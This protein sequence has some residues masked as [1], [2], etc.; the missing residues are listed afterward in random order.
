MSDT[1]FEQGCPSF[2]RMYFCA[3]RPQC[4]Y[5]LCVALLMARVVRW[6][7]DFWKMIAPQR[8]KVDSFTSRLCCRHDLPTQVLWSHSNG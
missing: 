1:A 5:M 4:G 2:R 7:L 8:L 6:L 3:V